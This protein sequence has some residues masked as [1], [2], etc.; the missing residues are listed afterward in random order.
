MEGRVIFV[1]KDNG[2]T[3]GLAAAKVGGR[4]YG[5]KNKDKLY[6]VLNYVLPKYR[7]TGTADELSF[8]VINYARRLGLKQVVTEPVTPAGRKHAAKTGFNL[9]R[10]E[11][12]FGEKPKAVR[13]GDNGIFMLLYD[14][15]YG[16]RLVV[17]DYLAVMDL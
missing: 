12:Y 11:E 9:V 5:W 13:R 16:F 8:A 3:V 10:T 1:A 15:G 17:P 7:G 2:T 4:L 14:M 6:F